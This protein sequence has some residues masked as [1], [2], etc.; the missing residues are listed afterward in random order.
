[1][2]A[3]ALKCAHAHEADAARRFSDSERLQLLRLY[4][5]S[6]AE[7]IERLDGKCS[8]ASVATSLRVALRCSSAQPRPAA[9]D[10][11]G[12]GPF[13]AEGSYVGR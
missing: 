2:N 11:Q 7:A 10:H 6:I 12:R 9:N 5:E 8:A 3:P 13:D 1:M 4:C